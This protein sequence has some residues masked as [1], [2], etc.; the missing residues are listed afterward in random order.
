MDTR[1]LCITLDRL[2]S[3]PD[4]YYSELINGIRHSTNILEISTVS[5]NLK[6]VKFS[7]GLTSKKLI[8]KGSELAKD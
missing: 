5:S 3:C 4:G 6:K 7:A 1:C 2:W 8:L